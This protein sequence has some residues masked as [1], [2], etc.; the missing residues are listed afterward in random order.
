MSL[1]VQGADK[2]EIWYKNIN[3]M[4]DEDLIALK[5]NSRISG[6]TVYTK[7]DILVIL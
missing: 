7:F 6:L 2:T 4:H 5:T 1:M 3:K